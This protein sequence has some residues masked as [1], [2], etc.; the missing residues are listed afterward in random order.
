M[1]AKEFNKAIILEHPSGSRAEVALFGATLT[2]WSVGGVERIFV[3]KQAKRDGSK[4][5]RGGIPICFPI[6][7]TKDTI[8]LPQHGF[9]R[10]NYWEY[11]GIVS[12]NDEVSV[13]FGLKDTQI[14]QEA[15]NAWPHSFRLTYTVSLTSGSIKT[16]ITVKNEDEDTFEF[17]TLLHTYFN[18]VT[19]SAVEGLTSCEYIDKVNNAAKFTE[20]NKKVTINKEVDRVYKAVKGDIFLEVGNDTLIK[21]E[22]S[23]LKDTVVWN[24]WVEKAES[25]NDFG[26]E[27]Y[28]NMICVEAGS[29]ADW[30][31]LGGGQTWTAG[32]TLT[33]L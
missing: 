7:G 33:V 9:A 12:D 15:R 26:N 24:P 4:A 21:I 25:M 22:K 29:V 28:K 31:T 17:N 30:V 20:E 5:I 2:S 32:Q 1:P 13:R 3:S 19:K 23:N 10:N 16:F 11:L 14:P 18:D 6:F 8:A 27:E